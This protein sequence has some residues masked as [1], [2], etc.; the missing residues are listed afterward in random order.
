ML[1]LLV[2]S[3]L[4][5]D[6]QDQLAFVGLGEMGKR[7]AANLAKSLAESGQVGFF[8]PFLPIPVWGEGSV[9]SWRIICLAW[10]VLKWD[11][12]AR[13]QISSLPQESRSR[14]VIA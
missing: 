5:A 9:V 7:M 2:Q 4:K 3:D 10:R 14:T 1:I 11:S 6:G 8:L 13:N 12:M